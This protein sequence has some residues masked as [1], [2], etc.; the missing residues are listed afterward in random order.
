MKILYSCLSKSWG[1]MEMVT[2]NSIKQLLQ[3]NITVEL[4]CTTESRIHVE[5][6]NLGM[7]IYPVKAPGYLHPFITAKAISIIKNG[8]YDLIHTHASKDLWLL[9]PVL[10]LIRSKT[11]LILTKHIGSFIKKTDIMHNWIYNR[12]NC[13]IAISSVIK[14]NLFETTSLSTDKIILHYNGVDP[15]KFD[16]CKVDGKKVRKEFKIGDDQIVLG[17][18][19]RFSAGKGHEE[20]LLAAKSLSARYDNLRFMIVGEASRGEDVYAEAIKKLAEEYELHNVI[21]TGFRNDMP[22]VMS[23]MDIFIF[24]SHAEAFGVALVEA[25]SMGKPSVCTKSDGILDITLDN[26]TGY[27]FEKN[28][29]EDLINKLETLI[30]SPEKRITLGKAARERVLKCFDSPKLMDE[31]IEIYKQVINHQ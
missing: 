27:F 1:G 11:A 20:F 13:A 14:R 8:R 26:E 21:F 10:K 12:V 29:P 15:V 24:P 3:K 5:A 18:A 31:L 23:A 16:P 6:N 7:I 25:M 2:I 17:M 19:A 9:V 30:N 22:E 28:N 4:I